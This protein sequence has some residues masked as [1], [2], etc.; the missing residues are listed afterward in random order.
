MVASLSVYVCVCG[1]MYMY[2]SP[3]WNKAMHVYIVHNCSLC[4]L[5]NRDGEKE[6]SVCRK[7]E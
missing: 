6:V 5:H 2:H 1:S 3:L 7:E 4:C